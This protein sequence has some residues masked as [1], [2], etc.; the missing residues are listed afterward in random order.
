MLHYI[1]YQMFKN[2]HS[3]V[4]EI[5]VVRPTRPPVFNNPVFHQVFHLPCYRWAGYSKSIRYLLPFYPGR[6]IQQ[7]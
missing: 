1:R 3:L 5:I 6:V 2:S 4:S 7:V